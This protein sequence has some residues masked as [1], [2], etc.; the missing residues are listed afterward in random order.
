MRRCAAPQQARLRGQLLLKS[1]ISPHEFV[2]VR[3]SASAW[4][5]TRAYHTHAHAGARTHAH[6]RAHAHTHAHRYVIG[7]VKF[8]FHFFPKETSEYMELAEALA[9]MYSQYPDMHSTLQY[10][11]YPKYEQ[12]PHCTHSTL[13]LLTVPRSTRST[14]QYQLTVPTLCTVSSQY[15]HYPHSTHSTRRM[16][17][18]LTVLTVPVVCTVPLTW[19]LRCGPWL[20][21]F[22]QAGEARGARP[23]VPQVHAGDHFDREDLRGTWTA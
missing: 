4:L 10:S 21:P 11:Q 12:F 1:K 9:H 23:D 16:H 22:S 7:L 6:T 15:S 14:L 20:G 17:S 2:C 8:V 5:H 18:T 13:T 19:N 3:D